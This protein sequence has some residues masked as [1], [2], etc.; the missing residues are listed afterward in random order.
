MIK[1]DPHKYEVRYYPKKEGRHIV[2]VTFAGQEIPK[3]PFE[4]HVGPYKETLIRA[5]GPGL[6]SGVVSH[7]AMFT[8]ET[9]G[10]TGSL[11]KFGPIWSYVSF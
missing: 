4:V 11:G 2:M 7:P 3:A 9:N 5:Y 8:V 6:T 1:I 10:E